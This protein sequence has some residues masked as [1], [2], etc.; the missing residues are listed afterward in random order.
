[1]VDEMINKNFADTARVRANTASFARCPKCDGYGNYYVLTK[2][3]PATPCTVCSE[4]GYDPM[5]WS[6]LFPRWE[7]WEGASRYQLE[8][9][10]DEE[11]ES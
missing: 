6:E 1:M 3:E 9:I 5:P 10:I 11:D 8:R 2:T 4:T 7:S